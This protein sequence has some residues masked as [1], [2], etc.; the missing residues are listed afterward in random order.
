MYSDNDGT[1]FSTPVDIT[2]AV[3]SDSLVLFQPYGNMIYNNG[4]L[5]MPYYKQTDIGSITNSA[6]YC[7]KSTDLGANWASKTV[8]ASSGTYRNEMDIVALDNSNLYGLVRDEVTLEWHCYTSADNGETWTDQG[9]VNFGE[10][11]TSANPLRLKSCLVNGVKII[12]CYY[13]D[14]N[15]DVAK[16]VY[17]LSSF[18]SK[19][20]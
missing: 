8:K 1:T 13:T 15:N 7:L 5:L 14:R 20:P 9:A 18:G 10:T 19:L 3:P 6:L 4:A 11:I 17:A 2:T 16:V 12:P